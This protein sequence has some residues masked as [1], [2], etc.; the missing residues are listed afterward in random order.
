MS[1]LELLQKAIK[2]SKNQLT[3]SKGFFLRKYFHRGNLIWNLE[4]GKHAKK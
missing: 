2:K 3:K 1:L 4:I